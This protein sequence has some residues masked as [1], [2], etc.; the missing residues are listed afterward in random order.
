MEV[1]AVGRHP[2]AQVV[3]NPIAPATRE[4][5][6]LSM[7]G[8]MQAFD[9]DRIKAMNPV[10]AGFILR[11]KEAGVVEAIEGLKAYLTSMG[12]LGAFIGGIDCSIALS[13]LGQSNIGG[14]EFIDSQYALVLVQL[15]EVCIYLGAMLSLGCVVLC[16]ALYNQLTTFMITERDYVWF[17]NKWPLWLPDICLAAGCILT[18][19]A[20][21][22]GSIATMHETPAIIIVA[23]A[24]VLALLLTVFFVTFTMTNQKRLKQHM[25]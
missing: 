14:G 6:A 15:Y 18:I 12:T 20:V 5:P 23:L 17:L 10:C 2:G 4:K 8:N 1:E 16:C 13:A 25:A 21:T 3:D 24:S 22:F 11:G 9:M 7:A 19:G